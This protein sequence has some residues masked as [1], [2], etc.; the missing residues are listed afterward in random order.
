MNESIEIASGGLKPSGPATGGFPNLAGGRVQNRT[1]LDDSVIRERCEQVDAT[2]RA[3]LEAAGIDVAELD[4]LRYDKEVPT[5]V[6]GQVGDTGW[7][8]TRGWYYWIAKGPGIPPQYASLLHH[9]HGKECRVEGHGLA[10]DPIDY[11]GGFGVGQYHVDTPRGLDA[12]AHTLKQVRDEARVA[13]KAAPILRAWKEIT[14]IDPNEF[15]A[16]T[17]QVCG[18]ASGTI[19]RDAGEPGFD[20]GRHRMFLT[21]KH[22]IEETLAPIAARYKK[23]VDDALAGIPAAARRALGKE[24]TDASSD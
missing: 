2:C 9:L 12:L 6:L 1:E 20:T 15:G 3:E 19:W 4:L 16:A 13:A 17:L 5:A 11:C 7:S 23:M 10:P 21:I 22:R 18:D 24:A 14:A 8:F